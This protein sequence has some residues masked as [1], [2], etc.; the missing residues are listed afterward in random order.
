MGCVESV[1]ARTSRSSRPRLSSNH[2]R[3]APYKDEADDTSSEASDAEDAAF[4]AWDAMEQ[5]EE[6]SYLEQQLKG[7]SV[8]ELMTKRFPTRG[9]AL[10]SPRG[11]GAAAHSQW[12]SVAAALT[13]D[14]DFALSPPY[15][16]KKAGELYSYLRSPNAKP[17]PRKMV[18]EMLIAASHAFEAQATPSTHR[19][20]RRRPCR[21]A[22]RPP[23]RRPP[24]AARSSTCR[25]PPSRVSGCSSAETRTASCRT[26]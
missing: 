1:P 12:S 20:V 25:R 19:R 5:A 21:Q 3:M 16:L 10:A 13:Y 6:L 15:T 26:S 22:Y 8:D 2:E 11:G 18:Y 24:P 14:G 4:D 17:L 7:C 23:V 9:G